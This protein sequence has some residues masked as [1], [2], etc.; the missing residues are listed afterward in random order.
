MQRQSAPIMIA[1]AILLICT[2]TWLW[3]DRSSSADVESFLS[4]RTSA[5]TSLAESRANPPQGVELAMPNVITDTDPLFPGN[6]HIRHV[7]RSRTWQQHGSESTPL[8]LSDEILEERGVSGVTE[9]LLEHYGRGLKEAGL[10]SLSVDGP[11]LGGWHGHYEIAG[12]VWKDDDA[13]FTVILEVSV[14]PEAQTAHLTRYI[15]EK[16]D[17]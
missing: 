2:T 9:C 11:A 10:R 7:L 5:L 16:V 14:L 8:R 6:D 3:A 17:R 12:Q 4:R 1:A 15:V 13:E